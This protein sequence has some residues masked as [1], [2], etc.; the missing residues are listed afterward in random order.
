MLVPHPTATR[1][2][3][4]R[5]PRGRGTRRADVGLY[6]RERI[7]LARQ[8]PGSLQQPRR[9]DL[10][11]RITGVCGR[12]FG[13]SLTHAAQPSHTRRILGTAKGA[14]APRFTMESED[15]IES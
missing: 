8:G 9:L 13:D 14:K 12:H 7:S 1:E 5:N 11:R 10:E 3:M 6:A 15:F 4:A 2:P